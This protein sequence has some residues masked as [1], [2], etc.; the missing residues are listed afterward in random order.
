[1]SRWFTEQNY[2]NC[3][4]NCSK[5]SRD[6]A[7]APHNYHY[8]MKYNQ[9]IVWVHL[10]KFLEHWCDVNLPESFALQVCVTLSP[11]RESCSTCLIQNNKDYTP[12]CVISWLALFQNLDKQRCALCSKPVS[13][14][15]ELEPDIDSWPLTLCSVEGEWGPV[16]TPWILLEAV[17][18]MS[19]MCQA[20][21]RTDSSVSFSP[22]DLLQVR[23]GYGWSA[24]HFSRIP[25][26]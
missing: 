11:S 5:T 6:A 22:G 15:D 19:L 25:S 8:L 26:Y 7:Q 9:C 24:L 21:K 14:P 2:G 12:N 18:M 3:A 17:Q 10:L 23:I 20:G 4:K 16:P 1:M 13:S